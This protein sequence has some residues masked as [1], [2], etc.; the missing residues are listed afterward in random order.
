MANTTILI[1]RETKKELKIFAVRNDRSM[2]KAIQLLLN[3]E[4]ERR[5]IKC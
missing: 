2:G 3:N 1:E 5:K 4:K